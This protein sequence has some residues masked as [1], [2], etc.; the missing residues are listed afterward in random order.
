VILSEVPPP[1]ITLTH[2]VGDSLG[3]GVLPEIEECARVTIHYDAVQ[4]FQV[5]PHHPII[6]KSLLV[7]DVDEPLGTSGAPLLTSI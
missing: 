7:C 5:S 3:M 6:H 1:D 2:L 4:A